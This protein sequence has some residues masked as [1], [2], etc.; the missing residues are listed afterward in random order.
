[1]IKKYPPI[2]RKLPHFMHGGDYNPDQW[3]HYPEILEE[4]IRLMKLANCN[5]VAMGIFSWVA[6]EPEEGTFHFDWLDDRIDKL[7]ENGIYTILSTPSGARPAWMS[8]KYPEVLRVASNRV[9]NLHGERHNHCYSSPVYREKIRIIN[10]RLAERY[11]NHPG[12]VAWHISNEYSGECHC[13]ICQ[14]N[15]RKWLKEK[16][17]SLENLNHAWWSS[18]WSHTITSWSQIESPSP[19]GERRTNGLNLDWKRFVTD[20]TVDFCKHEIKPF[21]EHN[22]DMP[23]TTNMMGTYEGLNYWKFK[24][25]LDRVSWDNYPCWHEEDDNTHI[26]AFI[27]MVHDMNRSFKGGKPFMLMEST[28]SVTNWS[29]VSKLKKPGMHLLSSLHAV[30]HGSDTVQYFQW[31]KS[32]GS[33]EQYHGAVVDHCGHENTRVF[34]DVAEVGEVLASLD[35]VVGTSV[36]AEVAILFDWENKWAIN[37]A[38]GPRNC[39]M[40]YDETVAMHYKSFWKNG[41]PVDILDMDCDISDYKL[42]IAPMLYMVRQGVGEKIERFVENG[43]TFVGT[44]WSGIV[45]ENGLCF[46]GGF[47][48]PLR[49]VLGIWS[50]ELECLYDHESNHIVFNK[51]N[52]ISLNGEF[53]CKDFC[54]L[55][56]TEGAEALA[57]YKE[58]FYAGRPAVTV[59]CVGAGKAY[60]IASRNG[61]DFID[62]FY[63]KLIKEAGIK[64]NLETELPDGVTVQR[65]S[66][67]ENDFIFIMNFGTKERHIKLDDKEYSDLLTGEQNVREINL[68]LYGMRILKR[69]VTIQ[70][71]VLHSHR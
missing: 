54:D 10:T 27:S 36:N 68:S 21:K 64:R 61:E 34:R 44:Y 32:R 29:P 9:R 40:K 15:F 60:Y 8:Q 2:S 18:F 55:I 52:G 43:G 42:L 51:E 33:S 13:D 16:Y 14:E 17:G 53:Q 6:L 56:H 70:D 59:N 47:P 37:D 3:L 28:P 50:E 46:L 30:A 39:G 57:V 69:R 24:D 5:T 41:I 22:P 7:Y 67:G 38:H 25:V 20:Q 63:G 71:S 45:D 62:G 19:I 48:G 11:S 26:A 35:E 23:V 66:D 65:R 49:K 31:R 12:V 4:D 1:M 58:D